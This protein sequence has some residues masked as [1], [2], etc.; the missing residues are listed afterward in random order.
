MVICS[1]AIAD[2]PGFDKWVSDSVAQ[3]RVRVQIELAPAEPATLHERLGQLD[4]R[5]L[6]LEAGLAERSGETLRELI[7]R[8]AC[9]M[10][11][12]P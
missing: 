2:A 9:D 10:L 11:I 5:L 4:C 6:A 12:V 1:P 3:H 8:V 7:G